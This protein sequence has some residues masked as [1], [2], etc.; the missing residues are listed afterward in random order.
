[1]DDIDAI[2]TFPICT[3]HPG[4]PGAIGCGVTR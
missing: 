2:S 4:R 1:M 3:G